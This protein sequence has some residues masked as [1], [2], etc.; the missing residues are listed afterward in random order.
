[1]AHILLPTDFSD[2]SLHAC[3]YALHLF[4]T[5][6]NTYTLVHAYLDPGQTFTAFPTMEEQLRLASI[7]GMAL[8]RKKFDALPSAR[9][10]VVDEQVLLGQVAMT[11]D[12]LV[13]DRHPDLI[14]MGTQGKAGASFLGSNA[15]EVVKTSDIPVLVI[16]NGSALAPVAKILFADDNKGATL[17]QAK[18]LVDIARRSGA[19][20]VV[21]HV[22][23][24]PDE[25]PEEEVVNELQEMLNGIPHR[26]ITGEGKDIA[27]VLDL[28]AEQEGATMIAVLH[29]HTGFFES[30]FRRST[31]KKLA[32]HSHTPLLVLQ[33]VD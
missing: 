29:R 13:K 12:G 6:G 20:V 24:D 7:Q 9:G 16:P 17:D 30:L 15:G 25:M 21:A 1:M 10:A 2:N 33:A 31:A 23:Q 14:A 27:A 4:G 32:L 18:V 3:D 5:V 22:S 11:L 28:L 19:E 8:W 26:F